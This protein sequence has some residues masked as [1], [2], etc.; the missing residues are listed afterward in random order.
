MRKIGKKKKSDQCKLKIRKGKLCQF[1]QQKALSSWHG[2]NTRW[3]TRKALF[4][5]SGKY[6]FGWKHHNVIVSILVTLTLHN[7]IIDVLEK[8]C[9]RLHRIYHP[10]KIKTTC[11]SIAFRRCVTLLHSMSVNCGNSWLSEQFAISSRYLFIL[12]VVKSSQMGFFHWFSHQNIRVVNCF[13]RPKKKLTGNQLCALFLCDG[14]HLS[15]TRVSDW[16]PT[17]IFYNCMQT[18]HFE[19]KQYGGSDGRVANTA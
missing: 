4:R 15:W 18:F 10:Q 11:Y 14:V 16:F 1:D 17:T 9:V 13:L 8:F 6:S 7:Q 12:R 2:W 3:N 19:F 5:T